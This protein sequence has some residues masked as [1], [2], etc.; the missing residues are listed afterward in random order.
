MTSQQFNVKNAFGN[1]THRSVET[2]L[3]FMVPFTLIALCIKCRNKNRHHYLVTI[4]VEGQPAEHEEVIAD[5]HPTTTNEE[6]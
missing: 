6:K 5:S 2:M 3:L 4:R 1:L